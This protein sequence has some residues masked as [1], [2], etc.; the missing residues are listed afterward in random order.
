MA[1]EISYSTSMYELRHLPEDASWE[2]IVEYCRVVEHGS[3]WLLGDLANQVAEHKDY[4]DGKIAEL[5]DAIEISDST[6][7]GY[8]AV[9]RAFPPDIENVPRGT[10]AWSVYRELAARD[11]RAD[12]ITR[13]STVAQAHELA[14]PPR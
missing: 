1:K 7:R 8:M 4:G 2:E 6:L 13:C 3:K 14:H 10:A 11:D 12:L 9:S 5:A